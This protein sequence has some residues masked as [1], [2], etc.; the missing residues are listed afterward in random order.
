M[1]KRSYNGN[2]PL[3]QNTVDRS[4][5]WGGENVAEGAAEEDQGDVQVGEVVVVGD[6]GEEGADGGGEEAGY[7]EGEHGGGDAEGEG[8]GVRGLFCRFG[9]IGRWGS[10]IC[11]GV[12]E[13]CGFGGVGSSHCEREG[14]AVCGVGWFG[15]WVCERCAR[16]R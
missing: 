2:P 14:C 7:G 1:Q 9:L 4:V 12:E 3:A 5:G 8:G 11:W 6:G 16:E 15:G 10:D 13:R